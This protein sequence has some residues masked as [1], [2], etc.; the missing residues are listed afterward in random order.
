MHQ[1]YKFNVEDIICL[2]LKKASLFRFTSKSPN[3]KIFVFNTFKI[4]I[5]N[6]K[7]TNNLS[8]NN[9]LKL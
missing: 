2:H 7:Y 9:L 6:L 1:F 8:N 3:T 4:T 5:I